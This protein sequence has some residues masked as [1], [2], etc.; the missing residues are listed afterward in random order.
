MRLLSRLRDVIGLASRLLVVKAASPLFL[1][2]RLQ[3]PVHLRGEIEAWTPRADN[4]NRR[5]GEAWL[6][7][8]ALGRQD[9]SSSGFPPVSI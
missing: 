6:G 9:T 3:S 1:P 2:G 5:A 7:A 8:D 4:D